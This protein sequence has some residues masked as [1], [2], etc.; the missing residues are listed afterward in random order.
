MKK[1]KFCWLCTL[2]QLGSHFT[3]PCNLQT[4]KQVTEEK[5]Q[6]TRKSNKKNKRKFYKVDLELHKKWQ[7]RLLCCLCHWGA[8]SH[9]GV[10]LQ[11]EVEIESRWNSTIS[12]C[13]AFAT[14]SR[15]C[16]TAVPWTYEPVKQRC[17]QLWRSSKQSQNAASARFVCWALT[18]CAHQTPP[19][20]AV[21]SSTL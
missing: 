10:A 6:E 5:K 8:T 7:T 9:L 21:L 14:H 19:G 11:W 13:A 3:P 17:W 12:H 1:E 16:H 15:A 4:N 2:V 18:W 20:F